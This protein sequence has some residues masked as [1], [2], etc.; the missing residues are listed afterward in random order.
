MNNYFKIEALRQE[1]SS[2]EI[3]YFFMQKYGDESCLK[4]ESLKS[5]MHDAGIYNKDA[6]AKVTHYIFD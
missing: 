5:F 3:Q 6:F 2:I 4:I 1:L